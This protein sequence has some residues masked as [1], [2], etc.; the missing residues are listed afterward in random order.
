[1]KVFCN[2]TYGQIG[3]KHRGKHV[4]GISEYHS[5]TDRRCRKLIMAAQL[6]DVEKIT[7]LLTD[8]GASWKF[9]NHKLNVCGVDVLG[10][11]AFMHACIS[12]TYEAA[13]RLLDDRRID[14][15]ANRDHLGRTPLHLLAMS[16]EN[17]L[18]RIHLIDRILTYRAVNLNALDIL[19]RK[20]IDYARKNINPDET[21]TLV[22]LFHTGKTKKLKQIS[23]QTEKQND[24]ETPPIQ[25]ND[26]SQNEEELQN[27]EKP[28]QERS[29]QNDK[30]LKNDE[31]LEPNL[32][33]D[34]T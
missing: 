6:N 11:D 1:M 5:D 24:D 13:H 27:E 7:F 22:N 33:N 2:K 30:L 15:T 3:E 9:W 26:E 18:E 8:D 20:P 25:Q 31:L 19:G 28:I 17:I 4:I 32:A 23:S 16:T 14:P 21:K 12:T 34:D 10:H 29:S